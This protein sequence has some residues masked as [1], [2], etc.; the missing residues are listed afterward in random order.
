MLH[1]DLESHQN[2]DCP[3]RI[4]ICKHCKLDGKAAEITT[5]HLETCPQVEIKCPNAECAV[6][7]PRCKVLDHRSECLYEKKGCIYRAFGCKTELIR[8]DITG[9]ETNYQ[10]HLDMALKKVLD[11]TAKVSTYESKLRSLETEVATG[12]QKFVFKI[13]KFSELKH[14]SKK[15]ATP[16][17]YDHPG[18]YKLSSTINANGG[19]KYKGKSIAIYMLFHRGENDDNLVWPFTGS[20]TIEVLNQLADDN[21]HKQTLSYQGENDETNNQVKTERGVAET[22]R[23]FHN[24]LSHTELDHKQEFNCQYLKDDCLFF[25]FTVLPPQQPRPWLVCIR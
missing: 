23:G 21:H 9:H 16:S 15:I 2:K 4:I 22:G 14:Q 24:F 17:F 11:L 10:L 20:I 19:G 5:T 18:G 7:V 8:K 3:N 12:P 13:E 1:K 6:I 25:R